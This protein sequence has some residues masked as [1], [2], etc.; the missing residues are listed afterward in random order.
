MNLGVVIFI[1]FLGFVALLLF[2]YE[3]PRKAK[4]KLTG[5][6]GDFE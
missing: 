6:G 4:R 5:R 3:R 2:V 1:A